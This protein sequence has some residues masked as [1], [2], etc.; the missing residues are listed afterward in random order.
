M[1]VTSFVET[2]LTLMSVLYLRIVGIDSADPG[3]GEVCGVHLDHRE[4][5]KP[6]NRDSIL[7]SKLMKMINRVS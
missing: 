2:A 3:I 7:Y 1:Q 4:I 5:C 6:R